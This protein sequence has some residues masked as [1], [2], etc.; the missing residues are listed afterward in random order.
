MHKVTS[1]LCNA[2]LCRVTPELSKAAM[3]CDADLYVAHYT[4]ALAA[5]GAT[6]RKKGT[7]IAFDAE[8]FETGYHDYSTGFRPLDSLMEHIE[9]EYLPQCSYVT[10]ASPEIAAAYRAKYSIPIVRSILNVFPLEYKPVCFREAGSVGPVKLYWFSQTVG[11]GRGLEDVVRAMGRLE[12]Y[13]IE[14]H[15]RGVP[16]KGYWNQLINL[17][18]SNGV[19]AG[20]IVLHD[21]VCPSESI[22]AAAEYDIG[23]A[24]EQPASL[25]RDLCLTNKIFSYLLAGN[26][27][28]A[29]ATRGQKP[30]LD[31][32]GR[33]GFLYEPGDING[34]AR[35]LQHWC[36]NRRELHDARRRAWSCGTHQFNWDVEKKKLVEIVTG[37]LK[38][39]ERVRA[40]IG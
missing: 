1:V 28:A 26:A 15:L 31:A 7:L 21:P 9:R 13:D 29:T 19:K 33:A 35:G 38:N 5:V 20:S 17:A 18:V 25:N 2:A 40:T 16:A 32:I 23:L 30:I 10:A 36:E 34:L 3:S 24:V 6:A 8:D 39:D 11:P 14:L 22:R 4:G 37:A 12:R 27:V